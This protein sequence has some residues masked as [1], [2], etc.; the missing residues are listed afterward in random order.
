MWLERRPSNPAVVG[1][2]PGENGQTC[3]CHVKAMIISWQ[4]KALSGTSLFISNLFTVVINDKIERFITQTEQL[5]K[6]FE[7]LQRLRANWLSV[8][9]VEAT[10]PLENY[11]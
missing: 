1:S 6:C 3:A 10:L 9:P 5:F 7:L 11:Y 4:I 2:S 8:K